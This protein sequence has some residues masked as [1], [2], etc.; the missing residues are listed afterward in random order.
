MNREL[1]GFVTE[2]LLNGSTL[3]VK[4]GDVQMEVCQKEK[5]E[6]NDTVS[7]TFEGAEDLMGMTITAR[8]VS[9]THLRAHET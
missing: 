8:A 4:A 1:L 6:E 2:E 7:Y 5:F 9:Y 3:T